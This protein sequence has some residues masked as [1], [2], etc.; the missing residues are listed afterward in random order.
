MLDEE[1]AIEEGGGAPD[2]G[3]KNSPGCGG[4]K[5]INGGGGA[6]PTELDVGGL[7]RLTSEK[8]STVAAA[9]AA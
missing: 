8:G 1:A 2:V 7:F 5:L 3:N 4:P 6:T 9:G